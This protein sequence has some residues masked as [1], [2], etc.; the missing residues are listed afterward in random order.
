MKK[1]QLVMVWLL[2]LIVIGGLFYP[3]LGYLVLAMMMVLLV[4]SL[5]KG[6]Y[7]CWNLCP[8]G[9]FLDIVMA[10][11][12][13][14]KPIPKIFLKQWFRWLVFILFMS[15]VSLRVIR[16]GG[17]WIAIGSVF[18]AMCILSTIVAIVLGVVT[19]HRAWCMICPMGTLQDK[20]GKIVKKKQKN[21]EL[22]AR[23]TA[24]E[25]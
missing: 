5:F 14:N 9:A 13:I 8:R 21:L 10:K 24:R 11:I 22:T 12:S 15:F 18:V 19:K 16:T 23:L 7:W 17:N 6:R 2:P 25:S 20:I 4:M 3:F 1:T